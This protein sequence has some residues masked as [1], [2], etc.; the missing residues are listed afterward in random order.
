MR[1]LI[2][3]TNYP[4]NNGGRSLAYIHTRNIL[5]AENGIKVDVINFAIKK[6][7]NIESI[8]VYPRSWFNRN[9]ADDYDLLILHAPNLRNHYLFLQEYGHL[10]SKKVFFFH[11]H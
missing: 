8:N 9:K 3:A 2:L 6:A 10:F 7:Y 11:G 4:D 5:Y 1:F